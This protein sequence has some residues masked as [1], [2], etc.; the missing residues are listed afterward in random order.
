MT[1]INWYNGKTANSA[2]DMQKLCDTVNRSLL[3]PESAPADTKIVA[4]DTANSQKMLTIGDGLSIEN[5]T[6]KANGGKLY[7]HNLIFTT[8]I[9]SSFKVTVQIIT[10]NN[11]LFTNS[12][13]YEYLTNNTYV[14]NG[15]LG[16]N[17]SFSIL[18]KLS[19]GENNEYV[20]EGVNARLNNGVFTYNN[21]YYMGYPIN[22]ID[23]VDT[24]IEL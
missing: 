5:D 13:L 6:L 7:R 17:N 3:T 20:F 10:K 22:D 2:S 18:N 12:T 15:I 21:A 11:T 9:D 23:L 24:V 4:V 16:S 1:K 14:V 8:P 19:Q